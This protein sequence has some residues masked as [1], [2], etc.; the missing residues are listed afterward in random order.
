M[1]YYISE[2][3]TTFKY[4]VPPPRFERGN[5]TPSERVD[6]ANLSMGVRFNVLCVWAQALLFDSSTWPAL[7]GLCFET[8]VPF[9]T[10]SKQPKRHQTPFERLHCATLYDQL[11]A[12]VF[13]FLLNVTI[14]S[15]IKTP[16]CFKF[17]GS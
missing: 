7:F 10:L 3:T 15:Q 4:M 14:T 12:Y 17:R 13:P 6:F 16:E 8:V 9:G 5:T 2:Y 1:L 11:I